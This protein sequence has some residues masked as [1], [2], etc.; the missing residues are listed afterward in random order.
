DGVHSQR[1][2]VEVRSKTPLDH[3]VRQASVLV[4][5]QLEEL[6]GADCGTDLLDAHGS[7]RRNAEHCAELLGSFGDGPFAIMMEK[8]LQR[9]WG[10]EQRHVQF[11]PHYDC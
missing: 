5:V 3:A 7:Q 11:L 4:E 9:G 10:A 6:W 8:S 2:H 1:Q